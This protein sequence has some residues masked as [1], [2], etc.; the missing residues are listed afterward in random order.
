[1]R[2]V[3]FGLAGLM[4]LAL[5][6]GPV[7]AEEGAATAKEAAE[8]LLAAWKANDAGTFVKLVHKDDREDAEKILVCTKVSEYQVGE[9]KETGDAASAGYTWKVVLDSDKFGQE[10]M[11]SARK[12]AEKN[13]TPA[14][15]VEQQMQMLQAMLPGM[16][17]MFKQHF[18]KESHTMKLVKA[19]GRWF[20]KEPLEA[21]NAGQ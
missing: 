16:L 13:G 10:L 17:P 4:M 12:Q 20:V 11:S 2:S 14:E 19:D 1:M 21:P 18:E 7:R 8:G 9:V 6:A 3:R 5:V 15:Q